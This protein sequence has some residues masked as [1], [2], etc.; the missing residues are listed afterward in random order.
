L[1]HPS[2]DAV[3]Q[4]L[5][6]RDATRLQPTG[7]YAANLLGLSDQVPMKVVFL[8]D[9]PTR[10]LPLGKQTITLKRTTP[11]NMATAGKAS[12]LV[13]QALRHLGQRHVDDNLI[14]Q[15]RQRLSDADKKQLLKDLA[16]APSWVAD[17]MR[18]IATPKPA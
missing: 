12:G 6:G 9:G 10:S 2:A 18:Q 13:I 8:T 1:L 3:A 4:A 7:G 11:K 5:A 14:A 16:Y 15:L 17:V